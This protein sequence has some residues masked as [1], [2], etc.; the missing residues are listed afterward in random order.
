MTIVKR[1]W[2]LER[3]QSLYN[4]PNATMHELSQE[5]ER[6]AEKKKDEYLKKYYSK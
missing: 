3:L 4:M 5:A 2:T 6:R 1:N